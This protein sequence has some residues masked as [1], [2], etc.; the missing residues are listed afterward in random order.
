MWWIARTV[1]GSKMH[2]MPDQYE[3]NQ[4]LKQFTVSTVTTLSGKS[5]RR[6]TTLELKKLSD[7]SS[8]KYVI[9]SFRASGSDVGVPNNGFVCLVDVMEIFEHFNHIPSGLFVVH[10]W[11]L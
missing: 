2:I 11:D 7:S 1:T 10:V 8:L 9:F 6:S 3:S 5:F 4:D